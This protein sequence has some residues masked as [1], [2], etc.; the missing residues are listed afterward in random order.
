MAVYKCSVCGYLYDEEKE[1][2]PFSEL[3]E[4]PV[5]KQ[6]P[7]KFVRIP[8]EEKKAGG[9]RAAAERAEEKAEE[10]R[11]AAGETVSEGAAED[12]RYDEA[13]ARRDDSCRYMA[14]IHEMAVTG[15]SISAAM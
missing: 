15:R 9:S 1:G 14:E 6:S 5:C 7:D 4:C 12:L 11:A 8:E 2:K 3:K 10:K 13:F